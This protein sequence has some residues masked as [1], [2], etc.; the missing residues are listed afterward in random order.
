MD[1]KVLEFPIFIHPTNSRNCKMDD[2]KIYVFAIITNYSL[3]LNPSYI[4]FGI[5]NTLETVR[6]P[7]IDVLDGLEKYGRHIFHVKVTSIAEY[8]GF[9]EKL[10]Q[11]EETFCFESTWVFE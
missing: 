10:L 2:I 9:N 6:T 11:E 7:S 4:D 1:S 3:E 8:G 5:V